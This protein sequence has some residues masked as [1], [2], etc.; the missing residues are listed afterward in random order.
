MKKLMDTYEVGVTC[1]D[2]ILSCKEQAL[3]LH[4]DTW[5]TRYLYTFA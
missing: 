2:T 4:R 1:G 5:K 3:N